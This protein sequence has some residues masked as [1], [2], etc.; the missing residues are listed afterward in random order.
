M[1]LLTLLCLWVVVGRE[2]REVS[3]TS[4]GDRFFFLVEEVEEEMKEEVEKEVEV[5]VEVM[6]W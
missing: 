4:E 3:L 5:E 1:P 2:G 6:R